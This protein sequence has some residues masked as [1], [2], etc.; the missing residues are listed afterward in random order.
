MQISASPLLLLPSLSSSQ[1][2]DLLP[3]TP[4]ACDVPNTRLNVWTATYI[5]TSIFFPGYND[6]ADGT[7]S[8]V[9]MFQGKPIPYSCF[10]CESHVF[11]ISVFSCW[12]PP[13]AIL[14]SN[15]YSKC[16]NESKWIYSL[17]REHLIVGASIGFIENHWSPGAEEVQMYRTRSGRRSCA[18]PHFLPQFAIMWRI[19]WT[20]SMKAIVI[21]WADL[22]V[23]R[24]V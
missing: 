22:M 7:A 17:M 4:V 11:L 9:S 1:E 5:R 2:A 16:L 12:D 20:Q 3:L 10:L 13:A 15:L 21:L 19:A 6:D 23:T 8:L 14:H 24:L 18:G